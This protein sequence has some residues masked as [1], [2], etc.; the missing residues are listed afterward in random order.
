MSEIDPCECFL[1]VGGF[2]WPESIVQDFPKTFFSRYRFAKSQVVIVHDGMLI[3][4]RPCLVFLHPY[5]YPFH[6]PSRV[7]IAS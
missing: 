7:V 1:I 5:P 3:D 4:G 2:F 6:F